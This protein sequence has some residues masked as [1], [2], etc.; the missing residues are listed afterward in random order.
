MTKTSSPLM[1]GGAALV[2]LLMLVCLAAL[3]GAGWMGWQKWQVWQAQS[4]RQSEQL[5]QLQDTLGDLQAQRQAQAKQL[6]NLEARLSETTGALDQLRTGGQRDWLL[7]EAASLASL[8]QQRL[9]LTGD[10]D[11]ADRLLAAADQVLARADDPAMLPA[12]RA[13]AKD[14]QALEGARQVDTPGLVLKLAALQER[15]AALTVTRAPAPALD[16]PAPAEGDW[17]DALVARLPVQVRQHDTAVPLPLNESQASLLR[18]TL[19]ALL[20][21]AQLALLQGRHGVY[22]EA[23]TQARAILADWFAADHPV[24]RE[25]DSTLANLAEEPVEQALPEIGSGLSAL[26]QLQGGS[27]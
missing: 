27:Q 25:L 12:R 18:L 23:L 8:A 9:L 3:L 24:A 22:R 11:A 6:D 15:V 17:W 26:R 1:Q 19:N 5:A 7:N 20:E 4:A 14:R 2:N 21:Q 13:L 10:I 16:K